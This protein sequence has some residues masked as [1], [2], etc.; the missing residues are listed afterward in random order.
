MDQVVVYWDT[1]LLRST[2]LIMDPSG[3]AKELEAS[4]V[5]LALVSLGWLAFGEPRLPNFWRL[6]PSFSSELH[7]L[8]GL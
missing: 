6:Q 5:Q 7:L 8:C 1:E 3:H 4:K 2:S